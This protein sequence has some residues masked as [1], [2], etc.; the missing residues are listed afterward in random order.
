[1]DS[2]DVCLLLARCEATA[3]PHADTSLVSAGLQ[4][5]IGHKGFNMSEYR[6]Y[7]RTHTYVPCLWSRR[8]DQSFALVGEQLFMFGGYEENGD[9]CRDLH[10]LNSGNPRILFQI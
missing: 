10:V 3:H 1:M 7:Q 4:L 9:F 2:A 6:S 8:S 5:H